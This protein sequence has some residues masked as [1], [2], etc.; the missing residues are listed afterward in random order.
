MDMQKRPAIMPAAFENMLDA[1]NFIGYELH[2]DVRQ[3]TV[4]L[5]SL[6]MIWALPYSF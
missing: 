5:H 6:R 3:V 4:Y 1:V 2:W